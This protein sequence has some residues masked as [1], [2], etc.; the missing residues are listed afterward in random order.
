MTLTKKSDNRSQI[1]FFRCLSCYYCGGSPKHTLPFNSPSQH[2]HTMS[3]SAD[4]PAA[5]EEHHPDASQCLACKKQPIMY[6]CV[7]CGHPTLCKV[8]R[9]AP[10]Q[11]RRQRHPPFTTHSPLPSRAFFAAGVWDENGDWRQVQSVSPA[12]WPAQAA[13]RMWSVCQAMMCR[14]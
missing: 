12:V 4:Q 10:A 9:A 8:R 13:M 3:A 5:Q 14:S 11:Q 6:A 7:P 1:T 2:S